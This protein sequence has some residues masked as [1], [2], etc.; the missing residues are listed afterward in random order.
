MKIEYNSDG[1]LKVPGAVQKSTEIHDYPHTKVIQLLLDLPYSMGKKYLSEILRGDETVRIKK[2]GF[3]R[4]DLFG[5]LA[6]YADTDIY[7]LLAEMQSKGFIKVER[8]GTSGFL[9]LLVV[10]DKGKKELTAPED[11]KRP[12]FEIDEVTNQDRE[13]FKNLG[14]LEKYNDEQKKGIVSPASKLLC[15]AGAGS[16]KT[17]VLTKR[18]EFLVKYKGVPAEKILAITFTRKARVEMMQRLEKLMPGNLVRVDTFNSFSEKILQKNELKCYDKKCRVLDFS[19][20]IKLVTK[21]INE[22]GFS[23][24]EAIELYFSKAKQREKDQKDLFFNLIG[25]IFSLIDHFKNNN[26]SISEMQNVITQLKSNDRM[27]SQFMFS[28]I[29]YIEEFKKKEGFRDYTDQIVH[30][31]EFFDK[32]SEIIPGFEHVLVDEYQ[33]VNDIQIRLIK[34]LNSPNLFVV[35]DPRQSIYG[36]RGSKIDYIYNFKEEY[37]EAKVVQLTKNYRSNSTIVNASNEVIRN[38]DLP[39]LVSAN[40]E[41]NNITFISHNNEMGENEFVA[42][43]I[44]SQTIDRKNIFILGRTNRQL[45]NIANTLDRYKIQYL[46]RTM[47]DRKTQIDARDNQ[48]TLSTVHA[49]KGLEA[50]L[51]YLIG[52]NANMYP[53]QA[54]EHPVLDIVKSDTYDKYEEERRLLY[55]AMTRAKQQLVINS[56]NT[57]SSF[58]TIDVKKLFEEVKMKTTGFKNN[59]NADES[60]ESKLRSWRYAKSQELGIK[61]YMIFSDKTMH[62]IC[63]SNPMTKIELL[64]IYGMADKKV[65]RYGQD[66]LDIVQGI[67]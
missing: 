59:K 7:N 17:T 21:A 36:W 65:Q 8:G 3:N 53:C 25:D 12:P 67:L 58:L 63:E 44:N 48:V 4:L 27:S 60:V 30:T 5:T 6:M 22:V 41:G 16:G 2:S 47:E 61:P 14:Y 54:R 49:I 33:D 18:I 45:R 29:Q 34:K 57:P 66:I 50:E 62:E 11:I 52:V 37:P 20:K 35:G 55:V 39:D 43:S 24:N 42:Q 1:S 31:L 10:T 40:K 13:V 23:T 26:Q 28:V 51:V 56:F 15:I 32:H 19:S 64:D 46:I 38:M 9:P